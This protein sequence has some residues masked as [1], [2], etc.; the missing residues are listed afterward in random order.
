MGMRMHAYLP[1]HRL[2][3][4]LPVLLQLLTLA[5]LVRVA[6]CDDNTTTTNNNETDTKGEEHNNTPELVLDEALNQRVLLTTLSIYA[7][8]F[9]LLVLVFC[10]VRQ[11]HPQVYNV[12]AVVPRLHSPMTAAANS[13]HGFFGWIWKLRAHTDQELL[14]HCSLDAV[15]VLRIVRLGRILSLVGVFCSLFLIPVYETAPSSSSIPTAAAEDGAFNET[16][17]EQGE[18]FWIKSTTTFL[19]KRSNRFLAPVAAAYVF[20]GCFMV[21]ILK[22][23]EWFTRKREAFLTK[24]T[25]QSYTV[26]VSAIP[27]QYQSNHALLQFFRRAVSEEA[28]FS[29]ALMLKIPRLQAATNQKTLIQLNLE[30]A[31]AMKD[32][33]VVA[34]VMKNMNSLSLGPT[35]FVRVPAIA[36]YK[37]LLEEQDLKILRLRQIVERKLQLSNNLPGAVSTQHPSPMPIPLE[38]I[39]THKNVKLNGSDELCILRSDGHDDSRRLVELLGREELIHSSLEDDSLM[40]HRTSGLSEGRSQNEELDISVGMDDLS[41]LMYNDT[42]RYKV[43]EDVVSKVAKNVLKGSSDEDEGQPLNVGF[44]TFSRLSAVAVAL[45][46]IQSKIPY[47]LIVSRAPSPEEILWGNVG[48]SHRAIQTGYVLAFAATATLCIFWTVPVAFLVSLTEVNSL[49]ENT[50]Y[51]QRWIEASPWLESS[52]NQI[53]PLLLQLI[54]VVVLPQILKA[55]SWMEGAAGLSLL[56]ASLFTKLAAFQVSLLV[57]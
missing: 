15:C 38:D 55:I 14:E 11:R 20:F 30:R 24:K 44:V 27:K 54:N 39:A 1:V 45:Q 46:V 28:V 37:K 5:T 36:H 31:Q 22:E 7:P 4:Q 29:A 42:N 50:K 6:K 17:T 35:S 18:E 13:Q 3:L 32:D 34:L 48:L 2:P 23:L 56:E 41:D 16:I 21:L 43:I 47:Q 9:V 26:C 57:V 25:A 8:L 12:R 53:S 10:F 51:V 19:P 49:K 40:Q 33:G 52:L